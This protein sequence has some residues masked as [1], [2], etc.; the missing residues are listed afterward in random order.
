MLPSWNHEVV[1]LTLEVFSLGIGYFLLLYYEHKI[2][3]IK[4][5][6]MNCNITV[7]KPYKVNDS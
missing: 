3:Q 6:V 4:I 2:E 1:R 5:L 7:C